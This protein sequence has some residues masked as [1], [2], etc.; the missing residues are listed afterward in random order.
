MPYTELKMVN[1]TA[2]KLFQLGKKTWATTEAGI[3]FGS[4][5]KLTFAP[6]PVISDLLHTTSNY[7]Y[8]SKSES[9]VGGVLRAVSTGPFFDSW[10]WGLDFLAVLIVYKP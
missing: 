2:G 3:S 10:D 4:G 9:L 6:Q 7:S 5:D 1:L 8:T